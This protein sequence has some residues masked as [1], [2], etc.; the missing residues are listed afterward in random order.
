MAGKTDPPPHRMAR[1]L[2]IVRTGPGKAASLYIDGELFPYFTSDGYG[3]HPRRNELPQVNF[4]MVAERVIVIDQME[5][6]G[7]EDPGT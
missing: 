7:G 4:T 2:K 3:V 5:E 1:E 6:A